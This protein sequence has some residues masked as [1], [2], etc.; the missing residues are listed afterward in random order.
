M[1]K[2]NSEGGF[3][4]LLLLGITAT[5]AILA[6]TLVV[7]IVNQQVVTAADRS[8][9]QSLYAAEAALDS[10]VQF[11]KVDQ[12]MSTTAEWLTPT[13][14]EAAF[15][16]VFPE[17]ATVTF[18]VY[19]NLATVDYNIKWDQNLDHVVWVEATVVYQGKTTRTR[20]LVQQTALPFAEAL[21]KSALYSDTG[22]TLDDTSDIYAVEDDGVTP[23]NPALHD[24]AYATYI[25]AG[26]T[27]IPGMDNDLGRFKANSSTNLAAPGSTIQSLGVKANGSVSTPGHDFHPILGPGTVG[28]LSDYFDQAAQASLADESQAGGTPS[29]A[30]AAPSSWTS[31]GFTTMTSSVRNTLQ[32]T[33]S[34]TTYNATA[35]LYL[36]TSLGSGHLTLSRGTSTTGRTFN[37]RRLYVAG[38]LTLTG[39]VTVNCTDLYVG[40][41]ITINN[42]TTTTVTDTLGPLYVNGTNASSVAGRV[43]LATT[44]FYCRGPLTI[45]NTT[46]TALTDNLGVFHVVGDLD[47][48]GNVETNGTSLYGAGNVTL[49]GST[50]AKTH[51]YNLVY[52][53]ATN[54]TL[55]LSGNVQL[56]TGEL[57][58]N[59]DFTI[60]DATTAVK[61][62]LGHVYVKAD[63]VNETGEI[64]WSGTASVTSRDYRNPTTDPLPMWM[65]MYWSRSGTYADEY[66]PIWVPGNSSTSVVFGSTG[67]SSILCPLLCTTEKTEVSGNITFGSRAQPMVYFFMCDN[68]GIYPQWVDWAS[69]GTYYGL[70]VI[71]ESTIVISNGSSTKPSIHG[72]IFAGCPYGTD[73]PSESDI[74]LEDGS[75]VAYDKGIVGVIATSSL[76]TTVLV[77]QVVP[78]SWQQLP[79]N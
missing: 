71:N 48:S 10:A 6:A 74:T 4:L 57:V 45:S 5:L 22:I 68:N 75:C 26:G 52:S 21:P 56:Y 44:S 54:K 18:K 66:G 20:V 76:K 40:G 34:T 24:G 16:D 62:W 9:K 41:R 65:G 27:W 69:T 37:F 13:D 29:A 30:P 32:S 36:P 60:S 67:A 28:F 61:N 50:A 79:V 33:S 63:P 11:A 49:T 47:V 64:N 15:A 12:V 35:N 31:T 38:N 3:A 14:L 78:G 8:S 58:A 51:R 53:N 70:M 43:N 46:S 39:P 17:D 25:M 77:T 73:S 59:G 2:P 72:A 7:V 1:Q 55:K 42:A 23:Y 19:D